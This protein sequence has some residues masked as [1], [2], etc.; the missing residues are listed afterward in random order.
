MSLMIIKNSISV[1]IRGAIPDSENAKEYLSSVEEQFKGT[2]KADAST[3]IL[4]MLTTKYDGVSGVRE[5]IMMMNG[6]ANKLKGMDM[7]I[8]EGFLVHFIMTSLPMQFGSFKINYNTQKEKWKIKELIAMCVQ[9]EE[10]LKVKKLDILHVATTNS[11]KRKGSWKG[12]G[13]CVDP[14]S[15]EDAITCDQSSHWREAIKDELNSMSKNNVW[16]LVE[17][18]KGA[19][20]VGCKWVFKTK[21]NPNGNFKR[22]KARLI[23]K[24]DE[25]TQLHQES[26]RSVR[27]LK[28][29]GS[30]FI[31]RVL[32]VD[33]ILLASNNIDLLH[34]SKHFLS[35]NF[36]MKDL[37]EASYVIG[38]E[39]HRDRANGKL[40]LSQKAYIER[41]LNRSDNLEVIG[42]SDSD[43]AKCKD[44]S[45]STSGY[46]F[47]L[48]GGPISWKSKKQVLTTTSTMMAEYVL[49]YSAT[50]HA[51]FLRNLITGLKIINSISRPLKI[52]CDN[53]AANSSTG[54]GLYLDTKYLFIRE[55]V[56]EHRISIEH[57]R[58][59][60]MLA[61]PL[62]K[63]K[64]T[65]VI[66]VRD[67]CPRGKG[68]LPC[69]LMCS[70]FVLRTWVGG[71]GTC[72]RHNFPNVEVLATN[73]ATKL[74][75]ATTLKRYLKYH[76]M[77]LERTFIDKFPA[78]DNVSVSLTS[79]ANFI[80]T[81]G[82]YF[83]F[84]NGYVHSKL[85]EFFGGTYTCSDKVG[86]MRSDKGPWQDPDIMKRLL[87]FF[88]TIRERATF[89][90]PVT[91]WR[92]V[93]SLMAESDNAYEGGPLVDDYYSKSGSAHFIN[94]VRKSLLCIQLATA[95]PKHAKKKKKKKALAQ[96]IKL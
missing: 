70:S 75:Q 38:I 57:I 44:T 61:H 54:A 18:P 69:C 82:F 2:S 47:M 53:S 5:H 34:E 25:E 15:F 39:I 91:R 85:P 36:D 64:I 52:Y 81:Y 48:S 92:K 66:L 80:C 26:S 87:D 13:K 11:N 90:K 1:A 24:G 88:G 83:S 56:E 72:T 3:L 95:K 62:T 96:V 59:Y 68:G 27:I 16:E 77:E 86:C 22:Y 94:H 63:G 31:I 79:F 43:F 42:Y 21:L 49:V 84:K 32:Y 73:D 37:G 9:E 58:T 55:I 30:N 6:I 29:S 4:K 19:K 28:M 78:C 67:R 20:P 41:V 50:C 35:R 46:I 89:F 17:L 7:K 33:D 74:M 45:R 14:E 60:E 71:E 65:V 76:V 51:M 23:T 10:R 40:G 12:K 8:S 93:R